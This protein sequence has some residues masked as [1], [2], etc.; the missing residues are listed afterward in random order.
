VPWD[1]KLYNRE[2]VNHSL[3]APVALGALPVTLKYLSRGQKLPALPLNL[4][5]L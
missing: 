5:I 1:L 4:S 3:G 2:V